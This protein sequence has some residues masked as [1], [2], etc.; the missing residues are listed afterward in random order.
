MPS[1]LFRWAW[2]ECGLVTEAELAEFHGVE[3]AEV[4]AGIAEA[5]RQFK[6]GLLLGEVSLV[7]PPLAECL[8]TAVPGEVQHVWQIQ[9]DGVWK[10]L[11]SVLRLQLT[12]ALAK[13][14][15][16]R[17]PL[18][19]K[20]ADAEEA[21]RPDVQAALDNLK[22]SSALRFVLR[23]TTCEIMS[24]P[25]VNMSAK[26]VDNR[27]QVKPTKNGNVR[28]GYITVLVDPAA[29]IVAFNN[30]EPCKVRALRV[31]HK[32]EGIVGLPGGEDAAILVRLAA[33]YSDAVLDGET[34]VS[35]SDSDEVG[36]VG[37]DGDVGDVGSGAEAPLTPPMFLENVYDEDS[38]SASD[39]ESEEGEETDDAAEPSSLDKAFST[40]T[41]PIDKSSF[42]A[43]PG[44]RLQKRHNCWQVWHPAAEDPA[45]QTW[46]W[47]PDTRR[48][49]HRVA[50][51]AEAIQK[52][53][54]WCCL[55][56]RDSDE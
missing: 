32:T 55:Q 2:S 15:L 20:L 23:R 1:S 56:E 49:R 51:E 5:Q 47:G 4:A 27:L 38:S 31:E 19:Q 46:S 22:A 52:C 48:S 26:V 54:A 9:A 14:D 13:Y 42:P 50:S 33:R 24:Q 36:D 37:D 30:E 18:L 40:H 25:W 45:S 34:D 41:P 8:R 7:C 3:Q 11:P 53:A 43:N 39:K 44:I 28:H 6:E 10:N 17:A 12:R 16:G 29:L 35:S 21:H